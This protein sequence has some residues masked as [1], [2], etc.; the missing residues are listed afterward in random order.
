MSTDN[1][2]VIR[3]F[4]NYGRVAISVNDLVRCVLSFISTTHLYTLLI[5]NYRAVI[6]LITANVNHVQEIIFLLVKCASAEHL[7]FPLTG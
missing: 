6:T 1:S 4:S 7:V 2:A 3:S 5:A